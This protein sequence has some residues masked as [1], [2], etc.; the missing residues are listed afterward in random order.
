M[1]KVLAVFHTRGGVGKSTLLQQLILPALG[2]AGQKVVYVDVA[3]AFSL[4]SGEILT[5]NEAESIENSRYLKQIIRQPL[6]NLKDIAVVIDRVSA[7]DGIILMDTY[8]SEYVLEVLVAFGDETL[9]FVPRPQSLNHMEM[10]PTESMLRK[11]DLQYTVV[12]TEE[13]TAIERIIY[14]DTSFSVPVI[15]S[16]VMRFAR[17]KKKTIYE[18]KYEEPTETKEA[19]YFSLIKRVYA[20]VLESLFPE[21][22]KQINGGQLLPIE[23]GASAE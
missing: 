12:R 20:P 8:P 17:K 5:N 6:S 10:E 13:G 19:M 14:G 21:V 23:V 15:N 22:L 16:S 1:R 4:P 3:P 2:E 7:L 18:L 9:V 11:L